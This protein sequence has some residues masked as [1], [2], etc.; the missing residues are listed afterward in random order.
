MS[1]L[2]ALS[3]WIEPF[4]PHRAPAVDTEGQRQRQAQQSHESDV[5]LRQL[6]AELK[7]MRLW[8]SEQDRGV[9]DDG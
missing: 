5:L 8:K 3:A 7:L 6:R 1:L 4:R 2:A 9:V